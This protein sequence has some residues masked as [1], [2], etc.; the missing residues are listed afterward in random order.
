MGTQTTMSCRKLAFTHTREGFE[1]FAQTRKAHLV[2]NGRQRLLIAMAPSGISWQARYEQLNRC[3]Y[4]VCLGHCQ[5]VR[6]NRKTMPDGTRK[7][8]EKDAASIFDLLR[9]GKCFLPGARDPALKAASRL[10]QRHMARKQRGNQLRAAMHLALPALNPLVK[11]LTHPTALRFLQAT[12]TPAAV[13]GHGRTRFFAQWQPR[14]RGGQW[15]PATFHRIYDLAQASLGLQAPAPLDV[16]EITTL[17]GDLGDALTQAQLWLDQAI[18]LLAHRADSQRLVPLPRIG[19]PTA[20]A[21]LTAIGDMH[22]YQNGTP[23][24]TRA[25]LARRLFE[26]GSRI[27]KLPKISHVGS[28]SLRYGLY[29]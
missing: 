18:A 10:M 14:Q 11:D 6:H 22:A 8:E 7:A 23:R 12:P 5:A 2:K 26:R 4:A 29:H 19:Q 1:R 24:V 13:L 16:F 3:G 17:A 28:A 21:L 25:G 9:Q 20:A 15:R 27:R